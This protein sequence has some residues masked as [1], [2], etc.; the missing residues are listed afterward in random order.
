MD[1]I[2]QTTFVDTHGITI[3]AAM[4]IDASI[5]K[6]MQDLDRGGVQ[7]RYSVDL[8]AG[9]HAEGGMGKVQ[10]PLTPL[11]LTLKWENN[12][13]KQNG[14]EKM[15]SSIVRGMVYGTMHYHFGYESKERGFNG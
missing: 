7:R 5:I 14:F 10:G 13:D 3:G 11:G 9:E 8:K 2:I 6:S 15:T 12:G 4:P 1:K